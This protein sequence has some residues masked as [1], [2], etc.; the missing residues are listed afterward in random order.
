M[1]VIG[2]KYKTEVEALQSVT[3]LNEFWELP[4][5]KCVSRFTLS[6]FNTWGGGFWVNENNYWYQPVLG[7]PYK[8]EVPDPPLTF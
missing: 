7:I 1:E 6:M 3:A 5:S 4:K 8:F 2:Y